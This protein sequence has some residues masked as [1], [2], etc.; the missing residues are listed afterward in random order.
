[1]SVAKLKPARLSQVTCRSPR[2]GNVACMRVRKPGL[3]LFLSTRPDPLP[4]FR[5]TRRDG[6]NAPD[7]RKLLLQTSDPE[8]P[9]LPPR[10][11]RPRRPTRLSPAASKNLIMAEK[12][13]LIL[14][15]PDPRWYLTHARSHLVR[16]SS[17]A[18]LHGC[19]ICDRTSFAHCPRQVGLVP[20]IPLFPPFPSQ[21][22]TGANIIWRLSILELFLSPPSPPS[23]D[24]ARRR[25]VSTV[26]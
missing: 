16:A 9:P 13:T 26:T 23:P 6:P 17:R 21:T 15:R 11:P 20:V 22:S 24:E 18:I 10:C 4:I 25:R 8:F 19:R 2:R 3:V 1:M 7:G 5:I 14:A 12:V